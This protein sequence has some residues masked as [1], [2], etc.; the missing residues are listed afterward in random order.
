MTVK[1][2]ARFTPGEAAAHKQLQRFLEAKLQLYQSRNDPNEDALSDLSPYMHFGQIS[3]QRV[4]MEAREYRKKNSAAV[5]SFVEEL[6]IRRELSDNFCFYQPHYD[7][8]KGSAGWAQESLRL[9]EKDAREHVYT[10]EQFEKYDTH[11]DLWN[12]AQK[13]LVV[14]VCVD[15]GLGDRVRGDANGDRMG[16]RGGRM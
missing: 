1:P 13:Q 14:E 10:V 3:A 7:S 12:A 11:D 16:G 5:Q 15:E 2:V 9:H 6:F 8:L 4:V